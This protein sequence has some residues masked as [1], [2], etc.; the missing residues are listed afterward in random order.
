MTEASPSVCRQLSDGVVASERCHEVVSPRLDAAVIRLHT[1]HTK[2]QGLVQGVKTYSHLASRATGLSSLVA[3]C[4][5]AVVQGCSKVRRF[6][7]G[8][9]E[10]PATLQRVEELEQQ[11]QMLIEE[12][13]ALEKCININKEDGA[14]AET[15]SQAVCS[16]CPRCLNLLGSGQNTDPTDEKGGSRPMVT[17]EDL[18]KVKLKKADDRVPELSERKNG[19]ES[20]SAPTDLRRMALRKTQSAVL[21]REKE[22]ILPIRAEDVAHQKNH[23]KKTTLKRSPGGT[24]QRDRKRRRES[25]QG[26]TPMMTKALRLK[27]QTQSPCLSSDSD[28]SPMSSPDTTRSGSVSTSLETSSLV[29][30]G[31]P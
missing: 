24:P 12:K 9:L 7:H 31:T 10:Y 1:L 27:F 13:N 6:V 26:L 2:I 19:F 17:L 29:T 23:L 18:Q 28:C 3:W 21:F 11:L 8:G 4:H 14:D 16:A 30:A 15:K 20:S 22:N 25:G 5:V